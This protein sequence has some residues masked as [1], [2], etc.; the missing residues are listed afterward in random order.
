MAVMVGLALGL[1]ATA[2]IFSVL[3]ITRSNTDFTVFLL[4]WYETIVADGRLAALHAGFS[5]YT[6]PYIYL[7]VLCSLTDGFVDRIVIVKICSMLWAAFGALQIYRI[8]RIA[9]RPKY[10]AVLAAIV[11]FT[12]PEVSLNNI[13]WGQSD[14]IYISFLLAFVRYVLLGRRLLAMVMFGIALSFKPQAIF[15]APFIGYL[16]AN[17]FL[18]AHRL[19][20]AVRDASASLVAYAAM[21][22]PA[23][24][25]G[26]LWRGNCSTHPLWRNTLK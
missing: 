26:R 23:I 6:P 19:I 22:L 12:L 25:A 17:D 8:C 9:E 18:R 10:F 16:F 21:M 7:L 11:F 4:P 3:W 14:I 2:I 15:I 1:S 5:D 20:E 24:L 13:V